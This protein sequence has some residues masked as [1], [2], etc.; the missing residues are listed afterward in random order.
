M[1]ATTSD[2]GAPALAVPV[3]RGGGASLFGFLLRRRE[4]WLESFGEDPYDAPFVEQGLLWRRVLV[5]NDP[6]SRQAGAAR[7][8]A[9]LY[10]DV[11][12]ASFARARPR[13]GSHHDGGRGVAA[14]PVAP[15]VDHQSILSY[16]PIMTDAANDVLGPW[17]RLRPG[18]VVDMSQEMM[19]ATLRI[20]TR[21]MFSIEP[22]EIEN[23]VGEAV[24]VYQENLHPSI[25]DLLGL[26]DW[27]PRF[28]GK[29]VERHELG[30]LHVTMDALTARHARHHGNERPQTRAGNA[31]R[32]PPSSPI[33][34]QASWSGARSCRCCWGRWRVAI[35]ARTARAGSTLHCSKD[36]LSFSEPP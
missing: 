11:H 18:A 9:E 1:S 35:L 20:I 15:A 28:G 33:H 12:R 26:P 34:W 21:T 22:D 5:V 7:Q 13:Q 6:E 27:I 36:L 30:S 4:N 24:R 16:A 19:C 3:R 17:T 14:S 8:C 2:R 29:R 32:W 25:F 23:S 31:D 10:E